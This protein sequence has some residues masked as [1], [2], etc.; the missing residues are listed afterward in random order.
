MTSDEI[1]EAFLRYFERNGHTRVPSSSLIPGNDPTLL[2]T[3][4][5]M[6]QFKE[7]FLG[8]EERPYRRATSVQRCVRAGGKHNDLDN[9]GRTARH[10]TFFEMLGNFSFGDYFKEDAI[11]FAWEF[12]TVELGLDP[13]RLWVTVFREDD[14]AAEL[15]QR[16][17]GLPPARIVRLG[18]KDNWWAMAETGPQGPSSELLI[19]RGAERACGPD[20]GIGRCDCDRWLEFWNLVFMQYDR[21]A[22][23][24]LTPLPK[25]SID[26]GMGLERIAAIV[27]NVESN[28]ETD[29]F[30]PIIARIEALC[31]RPYD[32]GE[33]GFPFRVIADH[34]RACTFL[35]C[36]GVLPSNEWRGYV[37]R[38]ILRRAVRFG[39]KLGMEGPFLAEVADAV[40]DRMAGAYPELV[41]RRDFIRRV[42][43]L[44]EERFG[45]TLAA[46]LQLL[47][48][49]IVAARRDG[50][51]TLAGEDAFRLYDTYGFPRELTEE[52]AAEHGVTVDRAGF[53]AALARQREQSKAS[54]RFRGAGVER[55]NAL[56]L[57]ELRF[58]G[59][60]RL[61]HTSPIVA[62]LRE[63]EPVD[64]AAEGQ[65]VELLVR[66]TPFYPEGGGQV[67]DTGT[68]RTA[69]GVATVLD[70]QRPAPE[71][72]V[73]RAVIDSG[74]LA[75]GQEARLEVDAPRRANIKRNHT[76]THLL[77]AALQEVLGPHARQAGS[78]VA[79]DRLRFD[80]TH[81]APVSDEELRQIQ[82][83]VARRI[84]E[85]LPVTP[86]YARYDEAIAAGAIAL[87]GE[88]YGD[89]V[90]TI[91]IRRPPEEE[92][93]VGVPCASL[94]LCGGTHCDRTGE[95]G[96]FVI[97]S[98]GSV[99]SGIRRIE[100]VTG[101]AAE[102]AI[103][104]RMGVLE[105]V[106]RRL[107]AAPTEVETRV[108]SLQAELAAER[109]RV[110][111]L[112]RELARREIEALLQRAEQVNGVTLLASR[113]TASRPEALREMT[114]WLRERLKSAVIVLGAQ[115]GD[116]PYFIAAVTPD[117]VAKG[118]H[119][120][121]IVRQAALLA[122]GGGGGRPELAQAGGKD[123]TKIE[124]ALRAARQ[125]VQRI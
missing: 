119:A 35:I 75:V 53:D 104:E 22:S 13:S 79:P 125:A 63:G 61:I 73:H 102:E 32:R 21:D 58:V 78:L 49:L 10:H 51:A 26:T 41:K 52:V 17:A 101:P 59:Y 123:P 99:G 54:A 39:R 105:S 108:A 109:R 31:R 91:C 69:T 57:P 64:A 62:L 8:L 88:K 44:E 56:E 36:D 4:A 76:A 100:A 83:W 114:D 55:F 28:W 72:I 112:E 38:R 45:R 19:D 9:V 1:R 81:L 82:R 5:G 40:V 37:L 43:E 2:F 68:V 47:D 33:A 71:I 84:Y 67:G 121:E 60:D 124:E 103:L 80:F 29:L 74:F 97:I 117:L 20:C 111:Q 118:Y 6:V 66:E 85:D 46:G 14:E 12:V 3:N 24:R 7:V 116:R 115:I 110:E 122:G 48:T 16:I 87:F 92:L 95:I 93:E 23:G 90:R 50:R 34:A 96:P 25:P 77:H 94:E 106:A 30:Q 27:Q 98:E 120:G 65:E 15:W 70:T 42:I 86:A 18:E 11:R 89:T 107:K 113:V